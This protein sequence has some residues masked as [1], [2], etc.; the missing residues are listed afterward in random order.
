[1]EDQRPVQRQGLRVRR[2][3]RGREAT[4]LL[5]GEGQVGRTC[6]ST[7]RSRPGKK[8][9]T[10]TST[11]S[12]SRPQRA[13]VVDFSNS[14]YDVNQAIVVLKGSQIASAHSLAGAEAVQVRRP[15]RD[16]ELSLRSSTIKPTQAARLRHERQGRLRAE[17]RSRSTRSSSTCRPPSTS[18]PCRCRTARSS[19]SFA[20]KPGGEHFGMVFAKGNPLSACVNKALAPAEGQR[21]AEADPDDLAVQGRRRPRPEVAPV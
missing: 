8:A 10:S 16:D 15:D 11:R 19:A 9:S 17:E 13:K 2:R 3:L 4:R 21:H 6:R 7:S 5:A 1:M 20:A 14:Y 18:P 12:R